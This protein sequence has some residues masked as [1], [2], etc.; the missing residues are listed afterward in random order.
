MNTELAH[1]DG[2]TVPATG[3]GVS[4][5]LS[6]TKA[7]LEAM[8]RALPTADAAISQRFQAIL[9]GSA[10]GD[11][12]TDDADQDAL[13]RSLLHA[14]NDKSPELRVTAF[15]LSPWE[16]WLHE[17]AV[18]GLD[19]AIGDGRPKAT[20]WL[21]QWRD[22]HHRLLDMRSSRPTRVTLINAGRL[23]AGSLVAMLE[24]AGHGPLEHLRIKAAVASIP[25]IVEPL[26]RLLAAKMAEYEP[27]CWETY[28]QLESC[29][30]IHG[31]EPEFRASAALVD[32]D[33]IESF[34]AVARDIQSGV[35]DD[36]AGNE[37]SASFGPLLDELREENE[38]LALQV[39]QLHE[40]LEF[41]VRSGSQ[42]RA[43]LLEAGGTAEAARRLITS[44]VDRRTQEPRN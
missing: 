28:E 5:L 13:M 10:D 34:L 36:V 29:A 40:E 18:P 6:S 19:D 24:A 4:A 16:A 15:Y 32:C 39:E 27:G 17:A 42:M 41:Q 25:P 22:Y 2:S 44:L 35:A 12:A 33:E 8:R 30:L 11:T 37:G 7:I 14:L 21:Q 20:E 9:S 31:R 23:D 38:L 1:D 3:Q 43:I 26:A